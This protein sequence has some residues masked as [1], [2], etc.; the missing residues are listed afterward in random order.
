MYSL[1]YLAIDCRFY[2]TRTPTA[3]A[4]NE[5]KSGLILPIEEEEDAGLVEQLS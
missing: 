1:Q 3:A 2:H 4:R 5:S